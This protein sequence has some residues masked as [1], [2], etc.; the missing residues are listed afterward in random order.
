MHRLVVIASIVV[1]AHCNAGTT[2]QTFASSWQVSPWNYYGDIAAMQWHYLPYAP[3][4]NSLGVLQEVRVETQFSGLR[5]LGAE[6]LRIRYAFFTG[7]SPADYQ[8]G[9]TTIVTP[10]ASQFEVTE[11]FTF[12]DPYQLQNW[13]DVTYYPPA[14]YYFESRTVAA[15]HTISAQTTLTYTFASAVSEPT[16]VALLLAGGLAIAGFAARGQRSNE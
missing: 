11:S 3:W 2:V 6:D 12:S 8:F 4:D 9:R 15:G 1:A 14:H 7:W 13:T 10:G 16:N 5:E